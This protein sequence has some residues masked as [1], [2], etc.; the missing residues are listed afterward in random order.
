MSGRCA[1]V[2]ETLETLLTYPASHGLSLPARFPAAA[3]FPLPARLTSLGPQHLK[4][5]RMWIHRPPPESAASLAVK[6]LVADAALSGKEICAVP[7]LALL[8]KECYKE[9]P[10][11]ALGAL[12]AHTTHY[13]RETLSSGYSQRE[14]KTSHL[15]NSSG[16]PTLETLAINTLFLNCGSCAVLSRCA[17]P[18]VTK[19][20]FFGWQHVSDGMGSEKLASPNLFH[21][22]SGW[23]TPDLLMRASSVV[24]CVQHM[25]ALTS[26]SMVGCSLSREKDVVA[27]GAVSGRLREL[28]FSGSGLRMNGMAGLLQC[29]LGHLRVLKLRRNLINFTGVETLARCHLPRLTELDL[30][31]NQLG[32]SAV[33]ALARCELPRL[34]MLT[35]HLYDDCLK[36]NIVRALAAMHLP[37]L[38][39]L[40]LVGC[41]HCAEELREVARRVF[42]QL[43]SLSQPALGGS[44]LQG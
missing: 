29:D 25:P 21:L 43:R 11:N 20:L 27:L 38:T 4:I 12:A 3:F 9:D 41:A 36:E 24:P 13:A 23:S 6:L 10:D 33:E 35:L 37:R 22:L 16:F 31:E 18:R 44:S 39:S 42:P 40:C 34:R 8:P 26:L 1:F 30:I 17:F 14:H 19:V 32:C 2:G 5:D 28:D 15:T 7:S